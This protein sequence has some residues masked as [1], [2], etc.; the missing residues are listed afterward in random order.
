SSS[1]RHGIKRIDRLLGN[2]DLAR[3]RIAFFAAI[4]ERILGGNRPTIVV[5]WTE[6]TIHRFCV[7]YAAVAF[8]GRAIPIYAETDP[9]NLLSNTR[10]EQRFLLQLAAVI[11][12]RCRPILVLDAGFRPMMWGNILRLG[13]DFVVRIRS[14]ILVTIN[15][16]RGDNRR[17]WAKSQSLYGHARRRPRD[18]GLRLVSRTHRHTLRVIVVDQRSKEARGPLTNFRRRNAEKTAAQSAR[19]PWLLVTSLDETASAAVITAIYAKRMQIEE[20]LRDTKNPRFGWK[21]EYSGS[22]SP[23]RIDVLLLIGAIAS[24]VALLLG[25]AGERSRLQYRYQANTRRHRRVLSLLTLGRRL[26]LSLP[27][28]IE[29]RLPIL[30]DDVARRL[31]ELE[32][33]FK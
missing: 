5:D 13:W 8:E 3:D 24:L 32:P 17:D 15:A 20:T 14:G 27:T 9:I 10:I 21:L 2:E 4:A 33:C 30:F 18:L 11:P 23:A 12:K 29:W 31:T 16:T 6:A 22:R 25:F 26:L 28:E 7:L 1:E 19:E